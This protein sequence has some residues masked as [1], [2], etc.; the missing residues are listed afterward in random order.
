MGLCI[1][2]SGPERNKTFTKK[3]KNEAMDD[4][5]AEAKI[6]INFRL[7][8]PVILKEGLADAGG[9]AAPAPLAGRPRGASWGPG[10][11][12]SLCWRPKGPAARG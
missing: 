8:N 6:M 1:Q 4:F 11:I 12:L 9:R 7:K 2:V 5:K 3:A 10:P